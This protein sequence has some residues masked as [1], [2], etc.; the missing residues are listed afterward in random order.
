MLTTWLFLFL[1]N[2]IIFFS[3]ISILLFKIIINKLN[4]TI[5]III[6]KTII[7]RSILSNLNKYLFNFNTKNSFYKKENNFILTIYKI[8]I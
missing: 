8:I 7:I 2:Q 4:I 1:N 3:K 6:I 5:K